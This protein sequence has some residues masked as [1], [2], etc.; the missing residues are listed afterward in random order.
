EIIFN[1]PNGLQGYFLVTGGGERIDK[2]PTAIV[3]DPRRPDRAVENGLSCMS[4]HH[5]GMIEKADQVRDHVLQNADAFAKAD[6]ETIKALY[7][8]RKDFTELLKKDAQRLQDAVARTGAPLSATEP[9]AALALRF[10]AELDLPLAAAEAGAKPERV[11]Q[12]LEVS[13]DLAK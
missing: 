1:L 7:P 8:P 4:C 9:I 2:G 3:S 5:H 11:L 10:E 13:A 12:A 6:L